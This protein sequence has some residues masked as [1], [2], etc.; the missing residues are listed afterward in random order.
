M[1]PP[2]HNPVPLPRPTAIFIH[3][4]AK[5]DRKR[6]PFACAQC[7]CTNTPIRRSGPL[8]QGT[9][10]NRCGLRETKRAKQRLETDAPKFQ[11]GALLNRMSINFVLNNAGP[12]AAK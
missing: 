5:R 4:S 1:P 7:G 8:G 6:E 2:Y 9:L 3:E 12:H 11:S 10:C